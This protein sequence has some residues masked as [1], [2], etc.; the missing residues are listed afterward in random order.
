MSRPAGDDLGDVL[1]VDLFLE[2]AGA[3]GRRGRAPAR[4]SCARA[5]EGC[6]TAAP[7]PCRVA[8]PLRLF[9]RPGAGARAL[10]SAIATP[11]MPPFSF[12]HCAASRVR[13]S[14]RPASSRSSRSRR[15][16]A[17]PRRSPC[18]RASRSISSCITRRS[19]SSSSAGIESISIRSARRG[20]VDQVDGL[21]GQEA[22]GD[23]A[24]RQHGGGDERRVLDLDAVV[25]LVALAQAA[26]DADRVLDR[27][28]ADHHRL[29]APLERRVLLD[30]LAVLVERRRADRVQL[31][32]R[33]HRL[34]QVG[35]HRCA[36]S[37]A[38]APT[39]VCSSSMNR[40][41]WPCASRDFLQH[42]LQALLE[43]AAVLGAR[44]ERA[45]VER[46]DALVA[47]APRARRRARCAARALRRWPSCRRRARRSAPGCSWSGGRAPG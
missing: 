19:T 8:R 10:P 29:E 13:S 24:I 42:G 32:A 34:E 7:T 23:V 9:H 37:A 36:P 38:P 2:H 45:H 26:Q 3:A 40:M 41:I 27:R 30:V 44:D 16:L 18:A 22:I 11:W 6:R 17:T 21:V 28:L 1:V 47:Q 33:Q 31:A 46:D 35:R 25:H 5:R 43:L 14:L 4:R 20:F 12:S 15:S 39:T